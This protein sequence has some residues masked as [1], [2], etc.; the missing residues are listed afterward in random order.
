MSDTNEPNEL[1]PDLLS[2]MAI[3]PWQGHDSASRQQMLSS[4]LSQALVIK[5][6]TERRTQTGAEA[7]IGK[8]T[9]NVKMPTDG[10]IIK[11]VERYP[12]T[13]GVDSIHF[14][15]QTVAL[16][17]DTQTGQIGIINLPTYGSLHQHFGFEYKAQE[18]IS[19]LV[20]NQFVNKDTIF[21]D[22]PRKTKAGGY[23]MGVELN[24]AFMS[25]PASSEDGVI[26]ARDVLD[27]LKFKIYE[28]IVV[29]WGAKKFPL[30]LYGDEN[31]YKIFPEI[32]ETISESG[33][34]M[35][36]RSYDNSLSPV[37]MS[38]DDVRKIDYSFDTCYH[39]TKPG[40]KI[41]DIRI[42]HDFNP[43]SPT[44]MGMEKQTIKY[45]QARKN[46][47]QQIL[48]E[49]NK[50][51]SARGDKLNITSELHRVIVEAKGYLDEDKKL[52]LHKQYRKNPLDDFRVEFVIEHE[53][54]PD[55][56]YKLTC[57]H[58]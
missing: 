4:H 48:T 15:P 16:Y 52:R 1:R 27:K 30:N 31:N 50:L 6:A 49:Y 24:M 3:N 51:H 42:Y 40:G 22:S 12:K 18:G 55:I 58:G 19:K 39:P 7:E 54:T 37:E 38:I 8:Y 25:H 53:I 34:L 5:G 56:G 28:N 44:P 2:Y 11:V 43:Q 21:L 35:A 23:M 57:F 20:Q 29:E 13:L 36:L 17:E 41:V 14:N 32:G 26:V 47:Y 10:K 45:I 33:V 9:F 46:F